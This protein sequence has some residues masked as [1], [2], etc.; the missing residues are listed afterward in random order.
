M[1]YYAPF[2]GFYA[3]PPVDYYAMYGPEQMDPNG[4]MYYAPPPGPIPNNGLGFRNDK[5]GYNH[6]KESNDSGIDDSSSRK[7]SR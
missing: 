6:R 2:P 5:T 3:Y 1:S 7:V 4:Q